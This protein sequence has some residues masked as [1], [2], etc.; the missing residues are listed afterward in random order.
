MER[1]K[2]GI[3]QGIYRTLERIIFPLFL[4]LYPLR[5]I[6]YG[7]E[8]WDTGYNYGNFRFLEQMD[9]MW[10]FGT[11]LAN[12]AGNLLTKLPFGNTMLG[13]NVYTGLIVS[14]LALSG[15]SFFVKKVKLPS[16]PVFI[17]E[18]VAISLCWCPTALLY[19]YLTYLL[20]FGGVVCLYLALT[21]DKKRYF[22]MAG[23]LFGI[24]VFVRFPNLAQMV[25]ILAVWAYGVILK[26][27]WKAVA[28]ETG[29]CILGYAAGAGGVFLWITLR[30]GAGNYLEAVQ[31]LF[32]MTSYAS[33]YTAYSMVIA[34]L[35]NLLQNFIWMGRLLPFVLLGILGFLVLPGRL[36][37]LKRTGYVLCIL[38]VFYW[39]MNQNMFNMSYI[40]KMSVFQWAVMLLS[41]TIIAGVL[42]IF[43]KGAEPKVKLLCGLSMLIIV[44]TPLGSNNHFYSSINNLFFVGPAGFYA[45]YLC[46][47]R[48]P[49]ELLLLK[50]KIKISTFPITAMIA[51]TI[52]MLL[53]QS[54]GFGICYVF[55]ETDGGVDLHTPIRGKQVLAGM[56]TSPDR[57]A[58]LEDLYACIETEQLSDREIILYGNIPSLA[59][60][61]DMP[62]A[63]SAWPDLPSYTIE[64]MTE[65]MKKIEDG[66]AQG[67]KAPVILFETEI[68]GLLEQGRM[69]ENPK[70]ML[71][72]EFI[73]DFGYEA[74][75]GNEKFTLYVKE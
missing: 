75:F 32:D 62:F 22:V 37:H 14:A 10:L 6:C 66:M 7:V 72:E 44:I 8:W 70:T 45:L 47:K 54:M 48:L 42:L 57:A 26:K 30:Y 16:L 68:A 49:G 34:Q 25:F 38:P 27:K 5:H 21:E 69:G 23:I 61:L 71:L 39:L 18:V 19:N 73:N 43:S 51:M 20:M 31:R 11:Y 29:L 35:R 46:L 15:Y 28:K 60:Y 41:Y 17:G 58:V 40:T 24:N 53:V 36:M 64:V 3:K 65:D 33:D 74:V 13:M 2:D 55:S 50:G 12:A 56:Y 4:F 67:E 1:Q 9:S 52:L 63:I 59:Y